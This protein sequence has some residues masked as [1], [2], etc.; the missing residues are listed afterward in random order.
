MRKYL[1]LIILC[2]CSVVSYS[3]NVGI[4]TANPQNK[5]HVA[6]GFRLDTLT[7]INGAGLLRHDASGVVYGIKFTGNI[8]DV[9]RGDGTFGS[10]SSG[11]SGT[12]FW[13]ANGNNIFNNNTGNV[14]V[15]T[16]TPQSKFHANGTSW[17]TG[18]NTP[19]PPAAGRGIAIGQS[20]ETVTSFHL[21]I[22]P[23]HPKI[24]YCRVQEG[25]S[26]FG[27]PPRPLLLTSM[28]ELLA[29]ERERI[30][31]APL[32]SLLK[33]LAGQIRGRDII[34]GRLI[35]VGLSA[36]HRTSMVINSIL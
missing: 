34:C 17:F 31:M 6:G 11:G 19:L 2:I 22:P 10:A 12:N 5:L 33:P 15:G 28:P 13:T 35:E 27:R 4:G 25:M 3:Q 14:G 26:A 29:A 1:V 32:I 18:D 21:I 24:F 30:P 16:T 7:G 9:L 36:P 8:N 23:S 20:G